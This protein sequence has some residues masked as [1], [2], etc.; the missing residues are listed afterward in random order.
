[1]KNKIIKL[2]ITFVA[3]ITIILLSSLL[4]E[5]GHWIGSM[6]FYHVNGD[7]TFF[8]F[9][10][11]DKTGIYCYMMG[12]LFAAICTFPFLFFKFNPMIKLVLW[13]IFI[14]HFVAFITEGI[15]GSNYTSSRFFIAGIVLL[16]MFSCIYIIVNRKKFLNMLDVYNG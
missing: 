12:G 5:V 2:I 8:C 9:F 11:D 15:L 4:H 7:I 14:T 3:S 1:M 16:L 6:L 13:L 10:P